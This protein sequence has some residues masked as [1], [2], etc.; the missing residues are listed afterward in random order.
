MF[1]KHFMINIDVKMEAYI[2]SRLK[3][4]GTNQPFQNSR[5]FSF[6]IGGLQSK[7]LHWSFKC[8]KFSAHNV[9]DC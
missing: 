2:A 5:I 8:I 4:D 3:G 1:L 9:L 6:F 7:F